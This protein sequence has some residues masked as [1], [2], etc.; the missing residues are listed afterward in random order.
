[1]TT[2]KW[3]WLLFFS[4]GEHVAVKNLCFLALLGA[5]V[6]IC[7]LAPAVLPT[8]ASAP[9]VPMS[10]HLFQNKPQDS[11]EVL[12]TGCFIIFVRTV[13]H[14]GK[15]VLGGMWGLIPNKYKQSSESSS[16]YGVIH[17]QGKST[18]QRQRYQLALCVC[19]HVFNPEFSYRGQ[20]QHQDF[21]HWFPPGR[22]L[23]ESR[24]FHLPAIMCI[25]PSSTTKLICKMLQWLF[26]VW[27]W[28][29]SSYAHVKYSIPLS[30]KL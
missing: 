8:S 23:A 1:M 19:S 5:M 25:S 18:A 30:L 17:S 7:D 15:N 20:C 13:M 16:V 21:F 22:H 6:W 27:L 9:S 29:S 4:P 24:L 10:T 12:D 28:K 11:K 14:L 3:D 26:T 2:H